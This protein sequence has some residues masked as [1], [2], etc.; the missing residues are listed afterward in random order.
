MQNSISKIIIYLEM[1]GKF[2]I[3]KRQKL[4]IPEE[5]YVSFRGKGLFQ[6]ATLTGNVFIQQNH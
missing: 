2:S 3:I 6:I 5:R 4:K 1:N